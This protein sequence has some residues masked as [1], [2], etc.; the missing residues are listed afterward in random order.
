MTEPLFLSRL[1]LRRDS[2]ALAALARVFDPDDG[3]A[4]VDRSH[5]LLWT[6]FSDGPERK[7]DFLWRAE[8]RGRYFALSHRPPVDEHR[9]FDIDTKTF[10]PCLAAGD[11]L[12]FSLRANAVKTDKGA[13]GKSRRRD[14]VMAALHGVDKN[15]RAVRR[16]AIAAEVGDAWLRGQGA[17][18]GFV[19][20]DDV[21]YRRID[22]PRH[23]ARDVTLGLFD[24][25]GILRIT[26]PDIFLAALAG[27]FGKAKGFGCGLML[28]RRAP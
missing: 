9:L 18:A 26:A 12:R 23:K 1:G 7:R 16:A 13:P 21:G 14:L 5:R 27:G 19:A 22:L 15:E 25:E 17:K 4:R 28:I 11:R 24:F 8:E 3:N 2:S 6:V 20:I 10:E